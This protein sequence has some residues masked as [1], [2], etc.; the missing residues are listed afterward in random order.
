MRARRRM[1]DVRIGVRARARV[2]AFAVP[3]P[4]SQASQAGQAQ[5]PEAEFGGNE[6]ALK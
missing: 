6:S 1:L 2:G 4:D 5:K 3:G